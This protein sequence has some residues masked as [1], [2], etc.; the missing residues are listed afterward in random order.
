M[1]PSAFQ[2][3]QISNVLKRKDETTNSTRTNSNWTWIVII[4]KKKIICRKTLSKTRHKTVSLKTF[5]FT[6][7][8]HF[9]LDVFSKSDHQCA[10]GD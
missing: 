5:S 2:L 6:F 8:F 3:M 1:L 9:I 4:I 7:F 10:I